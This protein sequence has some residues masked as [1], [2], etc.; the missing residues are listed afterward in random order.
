MNFKSFFRTLA[1]I[2]FVLATSVA[3]AQDRYVVTQSPFWG[4]MNSVHDGTARAFNGLR[5]ALGQP[6]RVR[7]PLFDDR[8]IERVERPR[9][10]SSY[11]NYA[12][13]GAYYGQSQGYGGISQLLSGRNQ[14]VPPQ[15]QGIHPCDRP[16]E[17]RPRIGS[18]T[19]DCGAAQATER[20]VAIAGGVNVVATV[21]DGILT[22][23]AAKAEGE[24]T[25]ASLE[26]MSNGVAKVLE[27]Q[28]I[29]EAP[30]QA[31]TPT[32]MT[33]P[34]QPRP[35]TQQVQST[36]LSVL[37][38]TG[39]E[40]ALFNKEG[41]SWKIPVS[42]DA[43]SIEVRS[44]VHTLQTTHGLIVLADASTIAVHPVAGR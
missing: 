36:K 41:E 24:K 33:M 4:Q 14:Q 44:G 10:Y 42:R 2:L 25:R 16:M 20:T 38:C 19:P 11:Q 35:V 27:M 22:R 31:Q 17:Y 26:E 7:Q 6:E 3:S 23:R 12:P 5:R 8:V 43:V 13:Q 32:R 30:Q 28:D 34:V 1:A 18:D 21:V 39:K 15:W 40:I 37:N 9:H 29:G